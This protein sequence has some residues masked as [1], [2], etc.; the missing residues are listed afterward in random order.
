MKIEKLICKEMHLFVKRHIYEV[1]NKINFWGE[2]QTYQELGFKNR[3]DMLRQIKE[4]SQI[5]AWALTELLKWG[6]SSKGLPKVSYD[7]CKGYYV[8][9]EDDDIT[10]YGIQGRYFTLSWDRKE[11]KYNIKEV[12]K[13]TKMVEVTTWEE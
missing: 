12:K 13:V 9:F 10:V 7:Y 3:T 11:R 6:M 4:D 5:A 1:E 2:K 8:I